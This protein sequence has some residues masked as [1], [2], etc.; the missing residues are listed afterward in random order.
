MISF[1]SNGNKRL[2]ISSP[3]SFNA[4]KFLSPLMEEI[5]GGTLATENPRNELYDSRAATS[6]HAI[7][8]AM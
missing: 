7:R 1:V 6:F 2:E 4:S 8:G 5:K 3:F